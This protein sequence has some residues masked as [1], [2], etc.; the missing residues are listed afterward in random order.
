MTVTLDSC[1]CV[2]LS[3]AFADESRV[4]ILRA[5]RDGEHCG[6]TLIEKLNIS[7]STLSYHMGVLCEAGLVTATR[8]GRWVRYCISREGLS[9]VICEL[10]TL[11][12]AQE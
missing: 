8:D 5:L 11:I 1:E 4:K 7:Q 3:K 6:R 12:D 10:N 9:R 2:R